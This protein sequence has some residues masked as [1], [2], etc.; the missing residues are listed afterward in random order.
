[1]ASKPGAP[2]LG[3]ESIPLDF[4]TS[5]AQVIQLSPGK[6]LGTLTN[7]IPSSGTRN[8]TGA[9]PGQAYGDWIS[10]SKEKV[11]LSHLET[12][13]TGVELWRVES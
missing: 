6:R 11:H 10:G 9:Q 4:E 3:F 12:R 1:M 8:G 2:Y 5:F 13:T 7:N